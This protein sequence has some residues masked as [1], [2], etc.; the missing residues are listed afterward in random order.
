GADHSPQ[1][2]GQPASGKQ[3]FPVAMDA[4]FVDGKITEGAVVA[5]ECCYGGQLYELSSLEPQ[6]GLCNVYLANK[7]YG[8]FAST[9]IAYGPDK[10]TG[11]ADF[12]CQFFMRGAAAGASLGRAALQARQQFVKAASPPDPSDIKTL[13]QFNLY[14]DP[15]I[16][17]VAVAQAV[18]PPAVAG[19]AKAK[20]KGKA[21]F[22][23]Q[24][25]ERKDRRRML[26]SQGAHIAETEVVPHRTQARAPQ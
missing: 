15:S 9:T 14:G 20:A 25:V 10:G 12:I 16:T 2:F 6:M 21:V 8:F 13:A 7:S 17:P 22:S 26:F 23:A 5:A 4:A 1:F 11:Q 19:K 18:V 24:R 3:E